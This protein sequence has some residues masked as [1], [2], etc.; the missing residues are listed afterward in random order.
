M[1]QLTSEVPR[2]EARCLSILAGLVG[3]AVWH[4][5]YADHCHSDEVLLGSRVEIVGN[6]EYQVDTCMKGSGPWTRG[7]LDVLNGVLASLPDTAEKRWVMGHLHLV[8]RHAPGFSPIWAGRASDGSAELIVNDGFFSIETPAAVRR[9]LLAFEAGKAF[10][11]RYELEL[12]DARHMNNYRQVQ[13]DM[14]SAGK[15]PNEPNADMYDRHSQ[16]AGMFRVRMLQV[17]SK[18]EWTK[19]LR[20]FDNLVDRYASPDAP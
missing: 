20:E 13:M 18:R 19:A 4:A 15:A 14:V 12:W 7:D 11:I 9:S 6:T 2:W 5:A 1:L 3:L 10:Y 8:R 16:F 17:P